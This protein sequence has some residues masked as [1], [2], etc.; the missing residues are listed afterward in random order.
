MSP[1]LNGWLTFLYL[2][3]PWVPAVIAMVSW[4]VK[5]VRPPHKKVAWE[6]PVLAVSM[7]TGILSIQLNLESNERQKLYAQLERLNE[8]REDAGVTLY[9]GP[10]QGA[11]EAIKRDIQARYDDKLVNVTLVRFHPGGLPG[12]GSGLSDSIIDDIFRQ[13]GFPLVYI[14]GC[15]EYSGGPIE[16]SALERARRKAMEV[17]LFRLLTSSVWERPEFVGLRR[18][19]M[20]QVVPEYRASDYW[21]I[22]T[23]KNQCAWQMYFDKLPD[24]TVGGMLQPPRAPKVVTTITNADL[25]ESLDLDVTFL[26]NRASASLRRQM[27]MP[28]YQR[29]PYT[30]FASSNPQDGL[31]PLSLQE[32]QERAAKREKSWQMNTDGRTPCPELDN[33]K[34][35][36][37]QL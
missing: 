21:L 6:G 13:L 3:G 35:I 34:E 12:G 14:V 18:E 17:Y 4:L 29:A 23:Q 8:R 28:D 22:R 10:T 5:A 27:E 9:Q 36:L 20:V 32:L 24:G 33:L 11:N 7:T 25:A 15:P 26:L 19:F 30:I 37:R 31:R 16:D 2:I 1:T